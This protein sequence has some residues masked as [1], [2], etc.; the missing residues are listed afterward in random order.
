VGSSSCR[1]TR[2]RRLPG[3]R[4]TRRRSR[5]SR[6]P[7]ASTRW[8]SHAGRQRAAKAASTIRYQSR[9][10]HLIGSLPPVR[11]ERPAVAR[12][13]DRSRPGWAFWA[14]R[15]IATDSLP[16]YASMGDRRDR[17]PP[18][19]ESS[20]ETKERA[21]RW[22]GPRRPAPRFRVPSFRLGVRRDGPGSLGRRSSRSDAGR[23]LHIVVTQRS[24]LTFGHCTQSEPHLSD[25]RTNV[26]HTPLPLPDLAR[27]ECGLAL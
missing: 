10:A 11:R 23:R 26:P 13:A 16:V 20:P 25:R 5:S 4:T 1:P 7:T 14:V 3:Q 24:H 17:R 12:S 21:R 15:P 27:L 9:S 6:A 22:R 8:I 19:R 18:S 2:R